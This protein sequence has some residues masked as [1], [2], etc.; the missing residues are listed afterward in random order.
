MAAQVLRDE[1]EL[2]HA[3][4]ERGVLL[5]ELHHRVKNNLQLIS[6]MLNMQLRRA[7]DRATATE[8]RTLQDRITSL[9]AIHRGLWQAPSLTRVRID[10]LIGDLG[11]AHDPP[12]GP[13][14]VET[15]LD[16]AILGPDE[17]AALAMLAAEA[18]GTA[19]RHVAQ[20]G[21]PGPVSVSLSR[22]EGPESG[23]LHLSVT[24]PLSEESPDNGTS[25]GD[26]DIGRA[27]IGAFAAQLGGAFGIDD[28]DGAQ[29]VWFRF[30]PR[31]TDTP[32]DPVGAAPHADVP[33]PAD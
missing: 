5:R 8:L 4:R 15:A 31:P 1:A 33:Q 13:R 25:T 10:T 6:S 21:L 29:V 23:P 26:A 7:T 2:E 27:M 14:T 18:I 17:A 19:A 28:H 9:A 32:P 3:M 22:P 11:A 12:R 16:P 20:S 24:H 30:T